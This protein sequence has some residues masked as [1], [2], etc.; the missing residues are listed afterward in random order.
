MQMRLAPQTLSVGWLD[1]GEED[2]RRAR[3]YLSQFNADN[4]LDELG[5]GVLRDAFADVFF[6][7][8][9]TIMTHTRYLIF[10]PALCLAVEQE[11]RTGIAAAR[12][13][14]ELE[15][16]LRESLHTE[17]SVGVIGERAKESLSRYPSSTYWSSIRRLGM[18]LH[19]NWG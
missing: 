13:L 15:N 6:P 4:T 1:L 5:F 18:F 2:Q 8:T 17:E 11:R 16:A 3:E 7:A 12:R 9:N 10:I 19:S 14:T